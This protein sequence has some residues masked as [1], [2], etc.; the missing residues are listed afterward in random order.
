MNT[1][2]L[3]G[4]EDGEYELFV[5]LFLQCDFCGLDAASAAGGSLSYS[6]SWRMMGCGKCVVGGV[7]TRAWCSS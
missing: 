7:S 2:D 6:V 1:R 4:G 3:S 5:D